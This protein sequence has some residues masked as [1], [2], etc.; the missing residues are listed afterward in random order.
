MLSLPS[1]YAVSTDMTS[2]IY[3]KSW[4]ESTVRCALVLTI[5]AVSCCI[6]TGL[7]CAP[8]KPAV[9]KVQVS[10]YSAPAAPVFT[11]ADLAAAQQAARAA[12]RSSDARFQ[13]A[14]VCIALG[15]MPEGAAALRE[16]V[17][18]NPRSEPALRTLSQLYQQ[19]GYLDR[20]ID[21]L[22]Q[23]TTLPSQNARDYM[24]L[25]A[26]YFQ[27]NWIDRTDPLLERA[28]RLNPGAPD[29]AA[30]RARLYFMQTETERAITTLQNAHRQHPENAEVA[31]L[32]AQYMMTVERRAEAEAVVRE[33][34][35]LSADDRA[36]NLLLAY[37]LV[38]VGDP[39][40]LQEAV[41]ILQQVQQKGPPDAEVYCHLGNAYGALHRTAEATAAYENALRFDPTFENVAFAL[42]QLYLRQGRTA[43][44]MRLVN[45]HARVKRNT[46][47]YLRAY[48][49]LRANLN[50]P[51]AHL[52]VARWNMKT[53]NYPVAVVECRRVLELRP[54]DREAQQGLRAALQR[55]GRT[56]EADALPR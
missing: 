9:T 15:N 3:S 55:A 39:A 42:G 17:R 22:R 8:R 21:T 24:R 40:R 20:E 49:I 46:Q 23:L 12:P 27:L 51:N 28:E 6:V 32:M 50:D 37:I 19:S 34:L 10:P 13:L 2:P 44:G 45:F 29:I 1:L 11:A 38:R 47:V 35:R 31:G 53:H 18:L 26:I 16:A 36:L 33:G 4:P 7:G 25:E 14:K 5:F 56:Q 30:A 52:D 43:E 54:P 48:E 41:A